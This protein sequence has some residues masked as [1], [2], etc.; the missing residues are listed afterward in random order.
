MIDGCGHALYCDA[1]QDIPLLV[2][3]WVATLNVKGLPRQALSEAAGKSEAGA[4]LGGAGGDAAPRSG[5]RNAR[6]AVHPGAPR[7]RAGLL[8]GA[9]EIVLGAAIGGASDACFAS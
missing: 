9:S 6:A 3:P 8:D 7:P 4:A 2:E 1:A 5:A